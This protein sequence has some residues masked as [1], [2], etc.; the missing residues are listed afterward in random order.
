MA[1]LAF[2]EYLLARVRID[3]SEDGGQRAG[4]RAGFGR[5]C[6]ICCGRLLLFSRWLFI[7]LFRRSGLT[8]G[9]LLGGCSRLGRRQ[10]RGFSVFARKYAIT[11][12][13]C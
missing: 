7:R 2:P 6:F 3:R 8:G 5:R 4:S 1:G 10:R 12:A 13:R 11:S 9:G